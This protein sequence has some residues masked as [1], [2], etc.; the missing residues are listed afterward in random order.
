MRINTPKKAVKTHKVVE[1]KGSNKYFRY[2]NPK[3]NCH[4]RGRGRYLSVH[5]VNGRTVTL[6]G[7]AINDL[8]AFLKRVGEI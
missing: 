7:H 2:M 1:S 8:T 5:E 6:D 4:H 3:G